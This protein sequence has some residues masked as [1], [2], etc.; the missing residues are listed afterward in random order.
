LRDTIPAE[1]MLEEVYYWRD[2]SRILD[3]ISNELK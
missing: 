1:G 2:M 3:G